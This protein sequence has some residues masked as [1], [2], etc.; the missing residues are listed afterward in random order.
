MNMTG[1]SRMLSKPPQLAAVAL[2]VLAAACGDSSSATSGEARTPTPSGETRTASAGGGDARRSQPYWVP[3]TSMQGSGATTTR[4]F[5]IDGSSLQ[6]RISW[7]CQSAPFSVVSVDSKGKESARKL[8]YA[9]SC[10]S[11]GQGFSADTGRHSLKVTGAGDWRIDVEQQVDA[12]LIE[13]AAAAMSSGNIVAQGNVYGVDKD[14]EGAARVH[15]LADGSLVLRLEGFYVS[16]NSDLEIRLSTLDRPSSTGDIAAAPFKV[17]AG[18]KA[19]VGDMNY[20]LPRDVDL[21]QYRSIVIW[22][23]I[24][25]NAYSA[26]AISSA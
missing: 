19:T 24:T 22:C 6:W 9:L 7:T 3:V 25:R 14:G 23:E 4:T 2:V 26:V 20:E 10:P 12:P 21:A 5:E 16:R 15:R 11:S 17:V 18:L 1:V 8:A 13:P